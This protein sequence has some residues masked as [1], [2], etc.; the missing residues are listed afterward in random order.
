MDFNT[1]NLNFKTCGFMVEEDRFMLALA[2]AIKET[3]YTS[4]AG[5]SGSF[6]FEGKDLFYTV[7]FRE[8]VTK[9]PAITIKND[10]YSLG[11]PIDWNGPLGYFLL[12]GFARLEIQQSF[13][14]EGR[15]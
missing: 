13:A 4:S 3:D 11:D 14:D 9:Q 5:G 10:T 15:L 8:P 6:T 12:L 7:W 1:V 2:T